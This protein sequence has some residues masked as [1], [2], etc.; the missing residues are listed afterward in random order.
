MVTLQGSVHGV[1][2]RKLCITQGFTLG[3]KGLT[4]STTV[5]YCSTAFQPMVT[6]LGSRSSRSNSSSTILRA[7]IYLELGK[8][9]ELDWPDSRSV[10]QIQKLIQ[11]LEVEIIRQSVREELR[12]SSSSCPETASSTN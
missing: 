1:K 9:F 11:K 3:V 10:A 2:V 5:K 8:V 4:K 6:L 7:G 12:R